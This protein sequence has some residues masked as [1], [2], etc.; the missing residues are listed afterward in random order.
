MPN[1]IGKTLKKYRIS[2]KVSVKK[3][4]ERLTA[5]GYK[6]SE[7]TIY[8][9]ENGNSSPTPGA[10]LEMYRSLDSYGQETVN[11]ILEREVKNSEARETAKKRLLTY[12]KALEKMQGNKSQKVYSSKPE[13]ISMVAEPPSSYKAYAAHKCVETEVT[14]NMHP[15]DDNIRNDGNK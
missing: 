6:A 10:L 3:I 5:K 15:C 9:W 4:S 2:S 8:S 12:E 14:D 11:I 7:S 1:E 13:E